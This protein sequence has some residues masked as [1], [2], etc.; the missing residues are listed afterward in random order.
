MKLYRIVVMVPHVREVEATDMQSAHNK[1][2]EL[3]KASKLG[4]WSASV[5]CVEYLDDVA[6]LAPGPIR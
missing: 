5:A 1:A 6:G 3:A 2:T 4:D